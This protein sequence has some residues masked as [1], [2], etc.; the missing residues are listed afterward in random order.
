MDELYAEGY[1]SLLFGGSE[2]N[3]KLDFLSY[4]NVFCRSSWR[5]SEAG[6]GIGCALKARPSCFILANRKRTSRWTR[7]PSTS[8]SWTAPSCRRFQSTRKEILFSVFQ[9]P[10]ETPTYFRYVHIN[11]KYTCNVTHFRFRFFIIGTL[12]NR[13]RGVGQRNSLRLLGGLR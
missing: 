7:R 3:R 12:S 4:M 1:P 10:L 6:K 2:K 11:R 13:A 8:S 9:R 5:E